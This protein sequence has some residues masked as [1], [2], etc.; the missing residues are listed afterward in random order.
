MGKSDVYTMNFRNLKHLV[1]M[2]KKRK[3]SKESL[4][5]EKKNMS[6]WRRTRC[7]SQSSMK[8]GPTFSQRPSTPQC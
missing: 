1:F 5:K 4:I 6:G 8:V 3:T 7:G 2:K